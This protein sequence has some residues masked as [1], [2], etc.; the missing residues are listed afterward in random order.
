MVRCTH[1]YSYSARASLQLGVLLTQFMTVVSYAKLVHSARLHR[2]AIRQSNGGH[3]PDL[4]PPTDTIHNEVTPVATVL[5]SPS[6]EDP[7]ATFPPE[8]T[9]HVPV[10]TVNGATKLSS[11][12]SSLNENDAAVVVNVQTQRAGQVATGG[13]V[14]EAQIAYSEEGTGI[15]EPEPHTRGPQARDLE[16]SAEAAAESAWQENRGWRGYAWKL[17]DSVREDPRRGFRCTSSHDPA[18]P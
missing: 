7:A 2:A 5:R 17:W 3:Q 16:E 15:D 13:P 6:N 8:D 9:S 1:V 4:P 10:A 11:P 18:T 12:P 14:V